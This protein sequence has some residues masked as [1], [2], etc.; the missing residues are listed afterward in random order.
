MYYGKIYLF[1]FITCNYIH[2]FV[3]CITKF[4]VNFVSDL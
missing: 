1:E 3:I 4:L 2:Y